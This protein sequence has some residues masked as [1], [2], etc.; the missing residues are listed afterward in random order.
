[1]ADEA[2]ATIGNSAAGPRG[3]ESAVIK[4]ADALLPTLSIFLTKQPHVSIEFRRV[5]D[6]DILGEV[7]DG[8]VDIG[9]TTRQRVPAPLSSVQ[10]PV[11]SA[12]FCVLLPR[13][14][15]FASRRELAMAMLDS[16]RLVTLAGVPPPR[17]SR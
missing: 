16:E 1:M 5:A 15:P 3:R 2:A 4:A 9:V 13:R 12:G 17:P 8:T 6:V 7:G 10:I 11:A 14:H